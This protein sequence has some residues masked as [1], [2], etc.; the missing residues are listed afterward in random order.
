MQ[1]TVTESSTSPWTPF[2]ITAFRNIWIATL[3]SNIGSG[4]QEMGGG[5]LMTELTTSPVMVALVQTAFS[6]PAF[7]L[8]IPAGALADIFDRRVYL[9]ATIMWMM[10]AAMV[11]GVFTIAGLTNEWILLIMT[12]ALGTGMAMMIPALAAITPEL[13]PRPEL[14]KAISLNAI[15]MNVSRVIGPAIAGLIIIALGIGAV[16]IINGLSFL[17]VL[18]VLW[19]WNRT[20]IKS[21]LPAERFM[22]AVRTGVRFTFHSPA[23]Q[24]TLVRCFGFFIFGSALWSLMP[25]V[26]RDLLA[27]GPRTLSLLYATFGI[28]AISS[29][30]F[31][32]RLR[33]TF[34]SDQIVAG[35]TVTFS[36]AL[37]T[38]S[39]ISHLLMAFVLMMICGASWITVISM[40]ITAGQLSLPN[41]VRSRGL[42]V[43][44]AILMGSL[45]IGSVIWGNVAKF[46]SLSV[47]LSSASLFAVIS[48]LITWR[49]H[50]SG[51]EKI[52][53]T[54]SMHWN[55]PVTHDQITHVRG[56]VMV[57]VDYRLKPENINEFLTLV[58][59]L[60][61]S[62]RRDGAYAW[63]VMEDVRDPAHYIEYYM[64][65][66]WVEH[67]RQHERVT[68]TE[69]MIQ[70]KIVQLL[71]DGNSP[72][73]RHFIGT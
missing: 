32:P 51:I 16:F 17:V 53:L 26:A 13:V 65:E 15:G 46:T 44:T 10:L 62:R 20:E 48:I 21:N 22:S 57:I 8:A 7:F 60:G 70:E 34:T 31:L 2:S 36:L 47:S 55:T 73:V 49:W 25:L 11:L 27:G 9:M 12:F 39:Q 19:K 45:A 42:S 37:F 68:N 33:T 38:I 72:E 69:R 61:R 66:S 5:W 18:Y 6:I 50:I 52:D 3:V 71:Q 23:L 58:H 63:D 30:L 59:E 1:Q 35:A 67:L 24:A 64:V 14:H 54:P 40:V 28:G 41:W 43:L 4:M 56:P 29:A